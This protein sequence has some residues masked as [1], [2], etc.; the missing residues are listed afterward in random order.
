MCRDEDEALRVADAMA[1]QYVEAYL[2]AYRESHQAFFAECFL[3]EVARERDALN[4]KD[5][6]SGDDV[7][8]EVLSDT[9]A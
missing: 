2:L 5:N 3:K 7:E 1:Q 8:F 6:E 4:R 9:A